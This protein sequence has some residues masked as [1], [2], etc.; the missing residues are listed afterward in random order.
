LDQGKVVETGSHE[1]LL[2]SNGSYAHLYRLQFKDE[3][4][5]AE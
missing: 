4:T 2:A 3:L 1:Q 5:T